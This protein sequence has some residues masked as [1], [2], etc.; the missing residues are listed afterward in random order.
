M[1]YNQN[2]FFDVYWAYLITDFFQFSKS[3]LK[4]LKLMFL[5]LLSLTCTVSLLSVKWGT[6]VASNPLSFALQNMSRNWDT[7][8]VT[9]THSFLL[10]LAHVATLTRTKTKKNIETSENKI[11]PILGSKWYISQFLTTLKTVSMETEIWHKG[12]YEK[13]LGGSFYQA[14]WLT[15]DMGI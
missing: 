11:R 10:F 3:P 2:N 8:L 5:K 1:R 4:I 6:E 15:C 7:K 13:L 9:K 12:C 14:R